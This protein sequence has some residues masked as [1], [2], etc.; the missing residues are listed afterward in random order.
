M[1]RV[2]L[3]G[4]AFAV[5]AYGLFQTLWRWHAIDF[6]KTD[7]L[8]STAIVTIVGAA[9]AAW[10]LWRRRHPAQ[11]IELHVDAQRLTLGLGG[12]LR[13]VPFHQVGRLEVKE[14]LVPV[15]KGYVKR[16]EVRASGL[17]EIGLFVSGWPDKAEA[18]RAELERL[19]KVEPPP[20]ART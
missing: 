17:P 9:L 20:P 6:L 11:W 5:G 8:V 13:H 12:P 16:Y 10:G 19:F 18:R 1:L 7:D 15:K 14:T 4:G 3:G 2:V